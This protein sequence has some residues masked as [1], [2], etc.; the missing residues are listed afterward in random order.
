MRW[1]GMGWDGMGWDGMGWD[2]IKVFSHRSEEDIN[3][4]E[5]VAS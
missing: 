3:R 2:V 1:D 4:E 5:S